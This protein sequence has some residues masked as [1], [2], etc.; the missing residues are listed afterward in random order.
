[1]R[2]GIF[3]EL[4]VIL[5][6][7]VILCG[8]FTDIPM[9]VKAQGP[10]YVS[11]IIGADT[12]WSMGESPFVV[13]GNI[14]VSSNSVLTILPGVDVRLHFLVSIF[15]EGELIAL[16]AEDSPITFGSNLTPSLPG[17]WI[18]IKF[19]SSSS[20]NSVIQYSILEH[21][22]YGIWAE[23]CSPY[24]AW[25]SIRNSLLKGTYLQGSNSIV[26]NNR[27]EDA[28]IVGIDL[29]RSN[30]SLLANTILG[31]ADVAVN[32]VE[33][34]ASVSG[35]Y[36]E[37]GIDGIYSRI[38]DVLIEGNTIVGTG[39][40]V[41]LDSSVGSIWGNDLSGNGRGLALANCDGIDAWDNI[42]LSTG[43]AIYA[44]FTNATIT[45][46]TLSSSLFDFH[47]QGNS[48]VTSRGT[49]FNPSSIEIDPT[50]RLI[51]QNFLQVVVE[52]K[53]GIGISG[54]SV[55]IT[56]NDDFV[57]SCSTNQFGYCPWVSL[58]HQ[59]YFG[60]NSPIY[61]ETSLKVN[62]G[63]TAFERNPR[64]VNM[65]TSHTEV[66]RV[67][68]RPPTINITTPTMNDEVWG[69]DTIA[70]VAT[71]IDGEVIDVQ[72]K[73]GPG[74]WHSL[75]ISSHTTVQWNYTWN[76][77]TTANGELI[78]F[79]KTV[80]SDGDWNSTSVSLNVFNFGPTVEI[81]SHE[82]GD[83]VDGIVELIGEIVDERGN[84]TSVQLRI[85][86]GAWVSVDPIG[87]NWSIWSIWSYDFDSRDFP[88]GNLEIFMMAGDDQ[89]SNST[90]SIML[91]VKNADSGS[92]L[93]EVTILLVA[94]L[95]VASFWGAIVVGRR[96]RSLRQVPRETIGPL[97][98]KP[99]LAEVESTSIVYECP[100]CGSEV[101]A[102]DVKCPS[103]GV[104]FETEESGEE[105][106][107]VESLEADSRLL[108]LENLLESGE[109]SQEIFD[110]NV[111]KLKR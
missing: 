79:A 35:N 63:N 11:G 9:T 40:A 111:A 8:A 65:N 13:T 32:L 4:G 85:N 31:T 84:V 5:L 68:N 80:D 23:G 58:T 110:L 94:V 52:E 2:Y 86:D 69:T 60:S 47:L 62:Y 89:P 64:S 48:R 22:A 46:S 102:D 93:F 100:E 55:D 105:Y 61:N 81:T 3:L 83:V 29:F 104:Q 75:N 99:A 38:S 7:S 66:F 19:N 25:N 41:Y 20:P 21:S 103:C 17:D 24:I 6:S 71:D 77:W 14:T 87:A 27:I 28:G 91:T 106:H 42:V 67:R 95:I 30:S 98:D 43:R 51:V 53:T 70:G 96:R 15:V 12:T 34:N 37:G 92:N 26:E 45:N 107:D 33:S 82:D 88:D 56:D 49:S 90:K 76:T 16:G 74:P 39:D 36:I 97:Q 72:L 10:T 73:I 18:A 108:A 44:S 1:M 54:A 50:A 101:H 59:T 109:I 57:N 78:V